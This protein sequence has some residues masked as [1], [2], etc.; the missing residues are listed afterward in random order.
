MEAELGSSPSQ[1]WRAIVEGRNVLALGLVKRIGS[2]A[3]TN[4]WRENWLPR[5]FK[6]RPICV[7][8]ADD[9]PHRVCELIDSASRQWNVAAIDKHFIQMDKEVILAIPLSS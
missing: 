4:I 9:P 5:D 2:G 7:S 1:V 3:Q 6:L 8:I